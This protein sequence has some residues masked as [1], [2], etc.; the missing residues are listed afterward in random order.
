MARCTSPS[1]RMHKRCNTDLQARKCIAQVVQACK[2]A[3]AG[4]ARGDGCIALT[5][6]GHQSLL[7]GAV[8]L[9]VH[10]SGWEMRAQL[11][12]SFH[13]Q[14][15][16]HQAHW[17]GAAGQAVRQWHEPQMGCQWAHAQRPSPHPGCALAAALQHAPPIAVGGQEMWGCA[18]RVEGMLGLQGMHERSRKSS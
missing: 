2:H 11:G 3:S 1:L 16:R 7:Q 8:I 13:A 15:Q 14:G 17:Q 9:C 18:T 12:C 10:R 5:S 4:M 6:R